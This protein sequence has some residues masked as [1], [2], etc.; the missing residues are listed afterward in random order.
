M[1]IQTLQWNPHWQCWAKGN[2]C[3]ANIANK[4][5]QALVS[6]QGPGFDFANLIMAEDTN[7]LNIGPSYVVLN[8]FGATSPP[9]KTCGRDITSLV[10]NSDNWTSESDLYS[11]CL[12]QSK[13][14]QD[15]SALAMVFSSKKNPSVRVLVVGAHF[16]HEPAKSLVNLA[17]GIKTFPQLPVILLA[18]T[19][20]DNGQI[21]PNKS[22]N[23]SLQAALESTIGSKWIFT[24]AIPSCCYQDGTPPDYKQPIQNHTYDVVGTN[25]NGAITM[26]QQ[27]MQNGLFGQIAGG[28]NGLINP[29]SG[30][31]STPGKCI[32]ASGFTMHQPIVAKISMAL[33]TPSRE[34]Y[35]HINHRSAYAGVY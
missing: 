5:L 8:K 33:S 6:P 27:Y 16:S 1:E 21:D 23:A 18:D 13:N 3:C 15:R 34:G 24:D 26:E 12:D 31:W 20:A 2:E 32:G 30:P 19:N 25:I 28:A 11:W 35:S 10:Y 7:G 29:I 17:T 9:P 4:Y 14:P 22:R